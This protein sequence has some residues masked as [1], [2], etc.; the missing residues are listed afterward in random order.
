MSKRFDSEQGKL[1]WLVGY[2]KEQGERTLT[3]TLKSENL[4]E[5]LIV[6]T[7]LVRLAISHAEGI[8]ALLKQKMVE[9]TAPIERALYELWVELRYL[10]RVGSR[11]AN[12]RSLMINATMEIQELVQD[13]PEYYPADMRSGV[14]KALDF[15]KAE[16]PDLFEVVQDQRRKRRHHWTGLSRSKMEQ[17]IAPGSIVYKSLS[18]EAHAL[19]Y[20]FRDVANSI[21]QAGLVHLEF[22]P[23]QNPHEQAEQVA[24]T[25]TWM[26]RDIW[27]D[28]AGEFGLG[29]IGV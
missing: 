14:A 24:N 22:K 10:L 5:L 3:P 23:L 9:P 21:V 11:V 15:Y 19:L 27:N 12:A 4:A 2:L 6:C 13:R 17:A 25:A 26:L 1:D 29:L 18:W 28:Y 8:N 7:G 20:P 16:N